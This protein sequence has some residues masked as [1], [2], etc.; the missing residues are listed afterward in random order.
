MGSLTDPAGE[1]SDSSDDED[2]EGG[3]G[4]PLSPP[5]NIAGSANDDSEGELEVCLD[6]GDE[7]RMP[8]ASP[9]AT[10]ADAV[11]AQAAMDA[12]LAAQASRKTA[13]GLSL[14]AAMES[15]V[16]AIVSGDADYGGTATGA[17]AAG[18]DGT[19]TQPT[20]KGKEYFPPWSP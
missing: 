14:V 7:K 12:Y 20:S 13:G 11:N 6:V 8:R 19:T 2:D 16:H 3:Y 17:A 1:A 4:R 18:T 10:P 15:S 5:L 9:R